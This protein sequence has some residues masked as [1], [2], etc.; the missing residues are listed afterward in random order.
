METAVLDACVLFQGKLTN[1]LLW[2]AEQGAFDPVWSDTISADMMRPPYDQTQYLELLASE[3]F[4][5]NHTAAALERH[6]GEL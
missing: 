4:G 1:L 5:L 2:L 3:R 6:R